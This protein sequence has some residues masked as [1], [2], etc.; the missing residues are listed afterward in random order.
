[1]ED[2]K[3]CIEDFNCDL[4]IISYCGASRAKQTRDSLDSSGLSSFFRYQYYVKER[5]YKKHIC[6]Y[7]GA[8]FMIDD[9]EE[10][11]NDVNEANPKITTILFGKKK[12]Q[13]KVHKWAENWVQ[14]VEI[15]DE[16]IDENKKTKVVDDPSLDISSFC[17]DV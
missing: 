14:V 8:D 16:I 15:I 9:R 5:E 13:K 12:P 1:M 6:N 7:L 10:I 11:L 4:Y 3:E 2:A 17:H